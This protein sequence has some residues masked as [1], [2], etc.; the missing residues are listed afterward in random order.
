MFPWKPLKIPHSFELKVAPTDA[1]NTACASEEDCVGKK[2][3]HSRSRVNPR[4]PF[5][6]SQRKIPFV[7]FS[8]YV[9]IAHKARI[10]RSALWT[11]HVSKKG[12]HKKGIKPG[13]GL[14]E[15]SR[16]MW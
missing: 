7:V 9:A 16:C 8:V 10:G 13:G 15:K 3:K 11:V 1:T 5:P 4:P 6:L 12:L 14:P 2:G